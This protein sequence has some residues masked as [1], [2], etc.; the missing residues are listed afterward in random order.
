M[1]IKKLNSMFHKHSRW[2]FGG[3]T[4]VIIVS[5]M[6]VLTPG[7]F[8]CEGLGSGLGRKVGTVYGETVTLRD[9]QN[10]M[11]DNELLSYIG[12]SMGRNMS[13]VQAFQQYALQVAAKRQGLAV[14]DGEVVKFM[15]N[16]PMLQENGKYSPELYKKFREGLARMGANDEQ[17]VDAIRSVLL[18][19]KLEA[20]HGGEVIVTDDE[21]ETF[22]R[23][24]NVK[25]EVKAAAFNTEAYLKG[26]KNDGGAMKDYFEKNVRNYQISGKI[27]GFVVAVPNSAFVKEATAKASDEEVKKFFETRPWLFTKY[28]KDGKAP[29]FNACRKEAKA[30]FI[31]NAARD[32][33]TRHAYE[34]AAAAYDAVNG[35][36]D[37]RDAAFRKAAVDAKLEIIETGLVDF[38]ATAVGKINSPELLKNLIAAYETHW[39]TNPVPGEEA[40]YVGFA[41]ERVAPRQAEFN[42]VSA[43]VARDYRDAEAMKLAVEAATKAEESLAAIED[44]KARAKAFGELKGCELKEFSFVF[45]SEMPPME[46][47]DSALAASRL[48]V[49]EV[50]KVL[51][52][53]AGAQL[54][55]LLKRT[56]ADMK[57]FAEKKEMLR[58]SYGAMKR[59]SVQGAF[60]EELMTQSQLDPELAQQQ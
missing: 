25:Y 21:L 36:G 1:I 4:I 56:P 28:G 6:G 57:G 23:Q 33:A 24:F 27:A 42:E 55:I 58:A 29:E 7:Q 18:I 60:W 10:Q 20:L 17:L 2:L 40:V 53:A 49:D 3:F 14:S 54:A 38:D 45:G 43:Q 35:A 31:K 30:E 59:Q 32:L 48:R 51:N 46:Y 50:S 19:S 52:T 44:G 37:A 11:R 12:L 16:L 34:F 39:V 9:L 8:G 13:F 26:V 15:R 47:I 22:Y 41:R 5:F